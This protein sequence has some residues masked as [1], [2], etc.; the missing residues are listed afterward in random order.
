MIIV[1]IKDKL[2]SLDSILPIIFEC[3]KKYRSKIL[4]VA[5]NKKTYIGIK[6]NIVMMDMINNIGSIIYLGFGT[7]NKLSRKISV[8]KKIIYFF[9]MGLLNSKFIHF[10]HLD[11]FPY[12]VLGLFF[13][14]NVYLVAATPH[15]HYFEKIILNGDPLTAGKNVDKIDRP[16]PLGDNF[17]CFNENSFIGL[18]R[19]INNL[20]IYNVGNIRISGAWNNFIR[21]TTPS[22]V[23]KNHPKINNKDKVISFM[24]GGF[25]GNTVPGII[26]ERTQHRLFEDVLKT[27]DTYCDYKVLIKPHVFTDIEY[28]K[29]TLLKYGKKFEITYLNPAILANISDIFICINYSTTMAEGKKYGVTTIEYSKYIQEEL[30]VTGYRSKGAP[31]IDYFIQ[32]DIQKLESV[33]KFNCGKNNIY[34]NTIKHADGYVDES[35]LIYSLCH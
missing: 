29:K 32:N 19:Y 27:L 21:E 24:L 3:N 34:I 12:N 15:E 20:K 1:F 11:V 22:Y 10:G 4:I 8:V 7:K 9:G 13:K 26:D 35:G 5:S 30:D 17:I 25:F 33:V 14:R 16:K 2:N 23:L 6:D 18:H 31:H 28:V